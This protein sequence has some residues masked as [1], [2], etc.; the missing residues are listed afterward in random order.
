MKITDHFSRE[1]FSC[2][3]CSGNKI[4]YIFVGKLEEL[5]IAYGKPLV[6]NSGYRCRDHN[7]AIGGAAKS[8]HISGIAV[9][10]K[11]MTGKERFEI[12]RLALQLGFTGIGIAN[13]FVHLD[14]RNGCG[15][16]WNY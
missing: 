3:C 5:R 16:V 9:D 15:I 13:S 2:P 8:K 12:L 1:E 7:A 4:D 10:L 6:I 11:V 14:I